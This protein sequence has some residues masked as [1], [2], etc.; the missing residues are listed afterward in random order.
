MDTPRS[1]EERRLAGPVRADEAHL[2][3]VVQGGGGL[4]EEDLPAVL[5]GD[6]VESD[7]GR[8]S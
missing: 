6:V 4:E 3:A 7:Q 1:A 2:L 5:L 8:G